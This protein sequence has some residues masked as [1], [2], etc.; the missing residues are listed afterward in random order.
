MNRSRRSF[1][2][3]V[4]G[5][6]TVPTVLRE[7]TAP[8]KGIAVLRYPEFER[9]GPNPAKDVARQISEHVRQGAVIGL[10][11]TKDA[12]GDYLWDFRI[13]GGGVDQ[14]EVVRLE[15]KPP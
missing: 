7:G 3:A 15:G 11:S 12:D 5:A 8:I 6:L 10:P 4:A 14:V 13:E 9:Y 2:A 1:I